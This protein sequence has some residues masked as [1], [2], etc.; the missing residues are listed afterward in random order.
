LKNLKSGI[1]RLKRCFKI[2]GGVSAIFIFAAISQAA[3]LSA[4][5]H[6]QV[7]LIPGAKMLIGQDDITIKTNGTEILEFRLTKRATRLEVQVN[8]NPRNFNF[9]NGRLRLTLKPH[10]LSGELQVTIHYAAKFDDPVPVHPINMDN[11]GFGVTATISEKGSFLLAGAG[12]YPE[13]VDSPASYRVTITAPSGLIAVT[14]G[15]SLGHRIKNGKTVSDWEVNYPVEGLS[16]SVARYVVEEKSVGDVTVA[17]YL[18]PHNRH[19]A[20]AYL[21]ATAGYLSLYSDLFGAYPFQKFAVVENFFPTGFGFPSYT[22]LGGRVLQ[23]PFII[24]TSLGHEIAHCWWGNGVYVDSTQGNWSEGLT[25][26]VA[27]YRFKEMKSREAA[28]DHRR[29]WLRNYSTL[30]APENDFALDRFQSRYDPVTRTIGYDKGAM[31]FHMIRQALGEEAFW[32]ALRDIYRNRLFRRTSW[33]DLQHAFE[34]RGKQSLQDFFDQWV[35][36]RGAP[37]FSLDGVRT[38]HTDSIWKVKGQII[39]R[40]PYFSFP[41]MLALKAGKQTAIQKILVSGRATSF[42]LNS[43]HR[44]QKLT[45]DP[46]DNI[47]RRL[48]ASEIP[49]AVNALK[50][51]P[52]VMT[53]LS[54]KLDPEI[55]KAAG[56]LVLS[57]GLKHNE[58]VTESE[59]DR[60]MLAENDILVI[61]FPRRN[62]LL[63]KMPARVIIQ[64]GSFSLNETLYEKPFDTFLGVFEHPANANRI[65]ALFMPLSPQ[66]ADVVARK[67][68]HYG[69]YSYLAFQSGKNL[70]KGIWPVE[71]SPLVYEWGHSK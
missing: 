62:D 7:E 18:L 23:L 14:A 57:L 33:S 50:S 69:K 60:Q 10:E 21:A 46:D 5:H 43:D 44:P 70:D 22:L 52:A 16:L 30:V 53:V 55:K 12:W 56:I 20:A 66:Y 59:L 40:R 2:L 42:E 61:G 1:N 27:D 31:V 71:T 28:R 65:A 15:R 47:F 11:P 36:R 8:K 19:L 6:I 37:R 51:S 3:G 32:G 9:E 45:A 17:T 34:I 68:T 13:L 39:Q 54:E 4:A 29:Q 38:E 24:R 63:Q 58:F 67:I 35:Y 49:P 41:L 64:S 48:S 25:T 26:Y